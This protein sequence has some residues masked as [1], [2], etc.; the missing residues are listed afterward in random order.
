MS[1]DGIKDI[2]SSIVLVVG[3]R[4]RNIAD[5]MQPKAYET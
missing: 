4:H 2:I 3:I 1:T 5:R